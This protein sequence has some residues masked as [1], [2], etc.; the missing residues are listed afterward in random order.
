MCRWGNAVRSGTP[1]LV[2][3]EAKAHDMDLSLKGKVVTDATNADNHARI[4]SAIQEANDGL[5]A[6]LPGWALSRDSHYQ[7]ANRFAWAWKLATMDIPVVLVYLGFLNAAEMQDRGDSFPSHQ[8][9]RNC[10]MDHARGLVPPETWES[11]LL[12]GN[13]HL[14]PLLRSADY[15][16]TI[17]A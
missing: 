2:L 3:V 16:V 12:G 11:P 10:M 7:V 9:W 13:T 6:I 14:V 5:N 15:S 4:G 1:G 8:E 17:R